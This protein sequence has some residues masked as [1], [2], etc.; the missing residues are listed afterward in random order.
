MTAP[1]IQFGAWLEGGVR[2]LIGKEDWRTTVHQKRH[3]VVFDNSLKVMERLRL[4]KMHDK[5]KVEIETRIKDGTLI[6]KNKVLSWPEMS[7]TRS[8][9]SSPELT[10]S[11]DEFDLV[12]VPEAADTPEVARPSQTNTHHTSSTRVESCT[13]SSPTSSTSS[14][15]PTPLRRS[16]SDIRRTP[17]APSFAP[18]YFLVGHSSS[19]L[20]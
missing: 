13:P 6:E 9:T 1:A 2:A 14:N 17:G 3:D 4:I 16:P 19:A 8:A 11:S 10:I 5:A 7:D 18:R 15:L 12:L 20:P